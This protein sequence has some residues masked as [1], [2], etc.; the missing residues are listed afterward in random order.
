MHNVLYA[1]TYNGTI[2]AFDADKPGN[3]LWIKNLPGSIKSTPIIDPTTHTLYTVARGS[4]T[5]NYQY[6][7]YALD[8][9]TGNEKIGTPKA[10]S[11]S[12]TATDSTT[13]NS[14]TISITDDGYGL[15]Q[16]AGLALTNGNLIICFAGQNED[17]DQNYHGWITAYNAQTFNQVAL[18]PTTIIPPATAGGVWMGGRAP[19]I[20]DDGNIYVFTG[21]SFTSGMTPIAN[22]PT[23]SYDG[24]HNFAQSLLKFDSNLKL[25]DWF[26]PSNWAYLDVNDLDLASS[27]SIMI[28]GTNYLTGGGKQGVVYLWD[29]TKLGGYSATDSNAIQKFPL[30]AP[31]NTVNY[32]YSGNVLWQRSASNGGSLMYD[33]GSTTQVFAYAFNGSKYNTTP[34]AFTAAQ[35]TG[36]EI[37]SAIAISANGDQPGSG[38][39]WQVQHFQNGNSVLR[40]FD[41]GNIHTELWNSSL[42][43]DDKL[44]GKPHYAPP[45]ISNGKVYIPTTS[46]FVAVYGLINLTINQPANQQTVLGNTATLA[47][48]AVDNNSDSLSYSATGLPTGLSIDSST[49]IISGTANTAGVFT[50][51]VTV[52][53]SK[54]TPQTVNFNWTVSATPT[55][56]PVAAQG[57]PLNPIIPSP[58]SLAISASDNGLPLTYCATGLPNGLSIN[59]A[60][61]LISGTVTTKGNYI[62][63]VTAS[64]AYQQSISTSFKWKVYS[65]PSFVTKLTTVSLPANKEVD[66]PITASFYGLPI[67]FT[68]TG[69]PNGL[70]INTINKTTGLISGT[71]TVAGTFPV[72]VTI[73][74]SFNQSTSMSFSLILTT[75]PQ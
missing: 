12:Y 20:D 5:K 43:L 2:Y 3:P 55:I 61:G 15:Q 46:N 62:V 56:T 53:N 6:S 29:A 27:G 33:S 48:Q 28:P 64:N 4:K 71:S 26:T 60:S 41:A 59:P 17:S 73:S 54:E 14:Y 51:S 68:A 37:N 34:A 11:G 39:L 21:N 25:L 58:V 75:D 35:P 44:A 63:T 65:P 50:V 38:I 40:A 24:Q 69:L 16:H 74:S 30:P 23:N 31:K 70:S 10:I 7:I 32:P 49:G 67:T 22:V 1:V 18:F 66:L 8:L 13:G 42:Y 36:F 72:T 52:N 57:T 47:I 19:T 45:T 9:L